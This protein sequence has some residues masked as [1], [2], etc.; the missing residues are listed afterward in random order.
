[1]RDDTGTLALLG[2]CL[3]GRNLA[4]G[5]EAVSDAA[6]RCQ[7]RLVLLAGDAGP[8][9]V[10]HAQALCQQGRCL[11]ERLPFSKAALG[12]AL[13]RGSAAVCAVTDTGLAAA[14]LRRLEGAYPGR[15]AKALERME[16]KRRRAAERR[17]A[18][19]RRAADAPDKDRRSAPRDEHAAA[20]SPRRDT[21]KRR[22][23]AGAPPGGAAPPQHR[24]RPPSFND[25]SGKPQSSKAGRSSARPD[26]SGRAR[27]YAH[28][29]P[30]KK[31]KGSF[32]KKES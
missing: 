27:R 15:Y 8:R 7:A 16:T 25:R 14:V 1:M 3:K 5:D 30:V 17:T 28:S 31:G 13:G 24:G 12:G 32:R 18:E 19:R 22:R 10:R 6:A 23:E 2:L 21:P 11:T 20:H 29:R 26:S 4:V 9:T